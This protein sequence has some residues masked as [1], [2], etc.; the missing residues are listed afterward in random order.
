MGSS[1]E[2]LYFHKKTKSV[3]GKIL[4]ESLAVFSLTPPF[5]FVINFFEKEINNKIQ[6]MLNLTYKIIMHNEFNH[7]VK[8]EYEKADKS[9][10]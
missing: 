8:L 10:D 9:Y 2:R 5:I 3:E 4:T 7:M 1:A 6:Y